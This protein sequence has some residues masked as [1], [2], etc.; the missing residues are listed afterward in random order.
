MAIELL[1]L[2]LSTKNAIFAKLKIKY[3]NVIL[4]MPLYII[5]W[6]IKYYKSIIFNF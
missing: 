4:S 3:K 2:N 6:F 5:K 1:K